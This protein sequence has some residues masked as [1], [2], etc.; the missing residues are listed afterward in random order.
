MSSDL[1]T[2]TLKNINAIKDELCKLPLD[3]CE[4]EY[5]TNNIFPL[6]T[7]LN[8]LSA[9]SSNLSSSFNDLTLSSVVH[10]KKS[11]IEDTIHLVY[12][13]NEECEDIYD[14]VKRR[15]NLVLKRQE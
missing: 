10:P 3:I 8:Q 2:E 6:L 11:E 14:I 9:V 13:I 12:N 4:N 15:I 5:V 1:K 7:V